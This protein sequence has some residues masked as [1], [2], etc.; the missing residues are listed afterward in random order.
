MSLA[1]LFDNQCRDNPNGIFLTIDGAS[2]SWSDV[3]AA[4]AGAIARLKELNYPED[5]LLGTKGTDPFERIVWMV[6]ASWVG[7][8]WFLGSS[9]D[10]SLTEDVYWLDGLSSN[11]PGVCDVP[12]EWSDD[13]RHWVLLSSGSTGAPKLISLSWS[14][15]LANAEGAKERLGL[16]SDDKWLCVLPLGHIAGA[17]IVARSCLIGFETVV[18][19][20][21]ATTFHRVVESR[22]VTLTSLV[23]TM[24]RRILSHDVV[25]PRGL[26]ALMVGGAAFPRDLEP[27][28]SAWPIW[29]TWGMSETA[30][31]VATSPMAEALESGLEP[32]AGVDVSVDSEGYLVVSGPIAPG[33]AWRSSDIGV[34]D[35]DGKVKLKGRGDDVVKVGGNRVNLARVQRILQTHAEH[36]ECEVFPVSAEDLG[37]EVGLAYRASVGDELDIL[38]RAA[39]H[40]NPWERPHWLMPVLEFPL[41]E[42]F[43]VDRMSLARECGKRRSQFDLKQGR[44]TFLPGDQFK[45]LRPLN[46]SFVDYDNEGR[47]TL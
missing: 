13:S 7:L 43:K 9:S 30:S 5:S 1:S 34:V 35:E 38:I 22:D 19:K 42:R 33:G 36:V 6:A 44:M 17:S 4:L 12:E 41:T 27:K 46:E 3:R 26:R 24:L 8:P 37:Y 21:D 20:F 32:I 47:V 10:E 16:F 14:Q 28:A 25:A 15:I 23:P 40:L 45:E 29:L 31:Q 11:R 18:E 2:H 39:D